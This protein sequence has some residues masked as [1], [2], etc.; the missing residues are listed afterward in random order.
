MGEQR[1]EVGRG[2]HIELARPRGFAALRRRADQPLVLRRRVDRG[3]KHSRRRGDPSVEAQLADGE[4][5]RQRLRVGRAD[6]RQQ[7][8]RDRQV[9]VRP[10]LG[11]VGGREVDGD[12]L[13]RKR[14]PDRG[15]R[16][17][18]P[19]AALAHRIVG[20]SDHGEARQAGRQLNLHLDAAGL[21]AEI[22]DSGDGR[23]HQA[24]P[25]E[26]TTLVRLPPSSAE[27]S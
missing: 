15:E 24:P 19:L 13:G 10:L 23:G 6:R 3:Q 22:S 9:V 26:H 27:Q 18:D 14:E 4:I 21:E 25:P 5:M 8:K 12:D 20:Q 16:R 11:Q 7:A 17:A 2:D 1:Q